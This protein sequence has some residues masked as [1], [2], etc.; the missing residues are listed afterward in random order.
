MEFDDPTTEMSDKDLRSEI[1]RI[2]Q[3]APFSGVS[4][5]IGSLR[6]RVLQ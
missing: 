2:K 5:I 1:E 4:K 6:A 3:D